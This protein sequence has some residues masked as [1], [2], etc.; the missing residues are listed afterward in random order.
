MARHKEFT[1][2]GFEGTIIRNLEGKY[3]L[4]NRSKNLQKY[5]TM[6]DQEYTVIGAHE[7][8][9]NDIGTAV[10]ECETETGI[11]FSARPKGSREVRK[12]YLEDIENIKSKQVTIQ[13]Q[14]KSEQGVPIFPVVLCIRDYE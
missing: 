3:E 4:K 13:Y 2:A 1:E 11:K 5:K 10:F 8:T 12:Q 9:G 6:L 7:G 14:E